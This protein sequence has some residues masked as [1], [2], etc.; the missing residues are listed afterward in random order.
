M[1][2]IEKYKYW[3][4]NEFF[5][6]ETRKELE[7]IKDDEEEIKSRFY[8]DLTFGTAGLRGIIGAGTNRMNKY[9]VALATQGLADTIIDKGNPAMERG[10]A[11]AYDV[12]HFSKDFAEVAARVLAANGIRY[13][14]LM[15]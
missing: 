2:Y 3:A 12:R 9:T 15:T 7:A 13:I 6:L 5:D 14:Y 10:V 4:T 11:I 8:T 1:D